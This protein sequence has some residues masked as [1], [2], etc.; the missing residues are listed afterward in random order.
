PHDSNF[1]YAYAKRM[2]EVQSRA[3]R[4]QN[5]RNYTTAIPNNIYGPCFSGDTEVLTP[6]GL[7]N[8]KSLNVGDDIYTLNPKTLEVE[9]AKVLSTTRTWSNETYSF[10]GK[11]VDYLVTPEHQMFYKTSSGFVK[12]PASYFK[13]RC[14]KKY[15]QITFAHHSIIKSS[16]AIG[17]FSMNDWVDSHHIIENQKV[18]DH[19]HSNSKP[20]P[21]KYNVD[22]FAELV[23]WYISEGLMITNFTK[24]GKQ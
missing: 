4:K 11:A 13:E 6:K 19:R 24:G 12:K 2:L 5:G 22:D 16:E 3:Y 8:I 7:T 15:G 1:G 10:S 21:L 23:V 14:G 17:V 18:R 20:F 9:I